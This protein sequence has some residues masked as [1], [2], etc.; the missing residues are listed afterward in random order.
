MNRLHWSNLE[1]AQDKT[2]HIPPPSPPSR[3]CHSSPRPVAA[4]PL[5]AL[6]HCS[7]FECLRRVCCGI[8]DYTLLSEG[9]A[10]MP[11]AN[12]TRTH[13]LELSLKFRKNKFMVWKKTKPELMLLA[14]NMTSCL[15]P[16]ANRCFLLKPKR[17]SSVCH[18]RCPENNRPSTSLARVRDLRGSAPLRSKA[19]GMIPSLVAVAVEDASAPPHRFSILVFVCLTEFTSSQETEEAD[20]CWSPPSP[21]PPSPNSLSPK[22]ATLGPT[23]APEPQVTDSLLLLVK[24]TYLKTKRLQGGH[25]AIVSCFVPMPSSC[26]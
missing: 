22:R 18:R 6:H 11:Q 10:G 8:S 3:S 4:S 20:S 23:P 14:G 26:A 12:G 13:F 5:T 7:L 1:R 16:H 24:L 9:H 21:V 17:F 2:P 19:K 25:F 15:V